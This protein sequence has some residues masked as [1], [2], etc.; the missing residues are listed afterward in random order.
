MKHIGKDYPIHDAW[1]KAAGKA[2]YAGDMT[3]ANMLHIA[4]LFSPIAHG[5]VISIDESAALALPGVEAVLHCF[6]LEQN[7][8]N[9][10]HTQVKQDLIESERVFNQQVRFVGDRVAAVIASSEAI[11]RQAVKLIKVEYQELPFSLNAQQTL[12]GIIDNITPNGAVFEAPSYH[13]GNKNSDSQLISINTKTHLDRIHH[14]CMENHACLADYDSFNGQLTIYS[15]NQTVYGIRSVIAEMFDLDYNKIRVLKTT[16]G[17]SFGAKQEWMLEPVAAACA[18]KVG[19]PVRLVYNRAETITSTIARSPIDADLSIDYY[20]DGKIANLNCD[21]IL[22]AGAYMGNSMNYIN[23]LGS[24]FFKLYDIES[25]AYTGR[26]TLS[27]TI[28]SGA[29][30]GWT[31]PEAAIILEHNINMAA[32]QLGIDPLQMRL[33]N[34]MPPQ[35]IDKKQNIPIGN[36]HGEKALLLGA[37]KFGWQQRKAEVATFNSQNS[38]YKRGIGLGLANHVS[39][40][41]AAKPDFGRVTMRLSESGTVDCAV[42]LHDHGCGTVTAFKMIAAEA[43]GLGI[44]DIYILEGDTA[45]TP[46]DLGCFSSRT[47]YVLGRATE[48]C[49]Y[50]LIERIK[51]HFSILENVALDDIIIEGKQ[52]S[53]QSDPAKSYSFTELVRKSQQI[54]MHDIFVNHEY[55]PKVNDLVANAHFALVE[56]D[57]YTGMTKIIDYVAIEDIGQPI[58]R[59]ICVAQTQGAVIMGSGAALNEHIKYKANGQ[60]FN[61]LKDYHPLN[62]FEAPDVRVYFVEENEGKN[63]GPFNSKSIGEACHVPVTAAIM[64]AVNNALDSD[65]ASVPLTPDVICA[66]LAGRD[67]DEA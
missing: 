7:D 40:Y 21:I 34:I 26:V 46:F 29:F 58:N 32:K 37:E 14:L 56:V 53:C 49:A 13:V 61:S 1:A 9:R 55:V 65:L 52:I 47:T 16:M 15:P 43:L 50:K 66:Y 10:Y 4:V 8:F 36:V 3:L 18:I 64:A 5:K 23:T 24:K 2:Q 54:H 62:A 27:N 33:K 39:G 6:N 22:D 12:S 20:P 59:E 57:T 45:R 19:K 25:T 41:Y 35:A 51:E 60:P 11:A 48:D 38:R 31:A 67:N 17:G 28:V 42:T 30:R 44:D 63:E